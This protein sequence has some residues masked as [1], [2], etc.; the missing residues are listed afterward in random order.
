MVCLEIACGRKPV[1]PR[2]EPSKVRLVEWVWDLYGNGQLLEAADKRLGMEFDEGQIKSLMVV[3]LWCCHPDPT[4]RPFIR[5]V[6]HVLNFEASLPF[7]PSKL[8]VPM[9]VGPSMD[10][11]KFSNTSSGFTRSKDQTQCS[12]SSCS[13]N[14]SMSTGPSKPLLYS[15]KAEVE[16]ASTMH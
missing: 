11:C 10:L 5:Q 15:S 14:S 9:Y 12:C 4:S 6:I 13:T 1:D 2:A 16:L 3:G 8:P 7:L